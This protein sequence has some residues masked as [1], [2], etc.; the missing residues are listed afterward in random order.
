MTMTR[1]WVR[2]RVRE[3]VVLRGWKG[4]PCFC[5]LGSGNFAGYECCGGIVDECLSYPMHQ[6]RLSLALIGW[7]KFCLLGYTSANVGGDKGI[8][9]GAKQLL[10]RRIRG[11]G[12]E[13]VCQEY[14]RSSLGP[15]LS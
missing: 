6:H 9:L 15:R 14:M 13:D 2:V 12:L 10:I 5:E 7:R 4:W 3:S 1:R 11:H 8:C